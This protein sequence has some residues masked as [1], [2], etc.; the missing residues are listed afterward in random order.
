MIQR[1]LFLLLQ[2]VLVGGTTWHAAAPSASP[3]DCLLSS[4]RPADE[5]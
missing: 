3:R 2:Q 4:P 1:V 5:I